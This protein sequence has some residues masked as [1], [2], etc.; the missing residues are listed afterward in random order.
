MADAAP[1][2]STAYPPPAS[3]SSALTGTTSA[4]LTVPVMIDTLTGA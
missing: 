3:A 4:L 2:I 1:A